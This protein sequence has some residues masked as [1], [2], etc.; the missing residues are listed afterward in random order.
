MSEQFAK[1]YEAE[2]FGQI[3]VKRDDNEEGKPE[4]RFFIMAPV[5]GLGVCSIALSFEDNDEGFKKRDAAFE[6]ITEEKAI[7]TAKLFKQ[8][9][10]STLGKKQ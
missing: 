10:L 4:V 9:L 5:A 8:D 2:G 6:K 1:L 3:L 7:E